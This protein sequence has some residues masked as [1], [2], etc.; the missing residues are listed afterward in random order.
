ML[1]GAAARAPPFA[2]CFLASVFIGECF[3]DA[4]LEKIIS[5][6]WFAAPAASLLLRSSKII[7]GDLGLVPCPTLS[8]LAPIPASARS[9]HSFK[10]HFFLSPI[11]ITPFPCRWRAAAQAVKQT[12]LP[13][14]PRVWLT[15]QLFS[16]TE[17]AIYFLIACL[18]SDAHLT[19]SLVFIHAAQEHVLCF[20]NRH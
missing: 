11:H 12:S 9:S 2:S 8:V 3:Q 6:Q 16:V 14:S 5:S 7:Q 10:A 13:L 19:D 4:A 17:D 1:P 15:A 18:I 20:I